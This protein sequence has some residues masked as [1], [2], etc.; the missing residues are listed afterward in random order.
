MSNEVGNKLGLQL[1][2]LR[3]VYKHEKLPT[4]DL[5]VGQHLMFQDSTSK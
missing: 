4:P 5:H 3:N 2:V 1:E